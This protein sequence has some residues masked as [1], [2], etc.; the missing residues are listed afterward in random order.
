LNEVA[1][2]IDAGTLKTFVNAVVPLKEAPV[3]YSGGVREKRG[4]GRVVISV[5]A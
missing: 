5:F 3:A 2:L 4:Y 1:R